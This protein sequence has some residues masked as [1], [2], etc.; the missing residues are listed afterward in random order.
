MNVTNDAV[1][2]AIEK[3]ELAAS[4]AAS[5]YFRDV[6]KGVDQYA[7]GY[8]WVKVYGVKGSTKLGKA[9]MANGFRK[10]YSGG[11]EYWMPGRVNCQNVDVHYEGAKAFAKVIKESLG[12]EGCYA[13]SRLD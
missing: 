9:L 1:K 5:N 6:L 8:A 4:I 3:A 7:C 12:I 2:V 13:D 10:C 11:L